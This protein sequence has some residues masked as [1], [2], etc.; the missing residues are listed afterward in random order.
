VFARKTDENLTSLVK[1]I[2]EQLGK[3]KDK[4]LC[5]FVVIL[6]DD[7]D[8]TAAALKKLAEKEKIHNVPLT[9]SEVAA[10]PPNYK[11]DKDAE[12]T[13]MLWKN[14]KVVSN[15]AFKSNGMKKEQIAAIMKDLPKILE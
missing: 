10:G 8:E 6:T 1:Q 15:H 4:K 2:D 13:V 5:A 11:I 12:V 3:N 9:I 7:S 14:L